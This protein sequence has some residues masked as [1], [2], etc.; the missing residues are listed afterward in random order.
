MLDISLIEQVH[1]YCNKSNYHILWVHAT[2]FTLCPQLTV[3]IRFVCAQTF[4]V[5]EDCIGLY[6]TDRTD[7]NT[8][9]QLI[10]V[11]LV[12]LSLPLEHCRVQCYDGA[13]N[14]SGRCSG[15]VTGRTT[16]TLRSL[17]GTFSQS[18]CPGYFSFRKGHGRYI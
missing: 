14:M 12:R 9:T 5:F 18:C 7:S 8:L 1:D 4:E 2:Q 3:C 17:H 15:V 13:S 11:V 16:S 6:S 10:K